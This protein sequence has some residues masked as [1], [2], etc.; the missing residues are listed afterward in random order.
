MTLVAGNGWVAS[1]SNAIRTFAGPVPVGGG[2]NALMVLKINDNFTG[3]R[4][5]NSAEITKAD[6]DTNPNNTPPTDRDST[7]GNDVAS[8]DDQ[9]KDIIEITPKPAPSTFDLAIV[10]KHIGA[11]PYTV[12][13]TV[14]FSLTVMNQGTEPAYS[15]EITDY[16]PAGL[17]LIDASWTSGFGTSTKTIAGPIASGASVSTTIKLRISPNFTGKTLTN[18][19]EISKADDDTNPTNTPPVDV[20]GILDNIQTNNGTAKD[21]VTNESNTTNA[22]ND[23]DNADIDR[24]DVLQNP[25]RGSIGNY[26]FLDNDGSNTQTS[27][28]TPVVGVKVYL[29]NSSGIKMDSTNT[30]N[31]GQYLFSNL[32]LDTYSVQFVAPVGNLFVVPNQ[33]G[34]TTKDSDA[35]S[36]GQTKQVTLTAAIPNLAV[37]DAGIKANPGCISDLIIT[38]GALVESCKGK[39]YP[40]LTGIVVVGSGDAGTIDWYKKA[41]GGVAVATGT[42]SYTPAGNVMVND[43]FYLEGRNTIQN[44][45][46]QFLPRKR[47]VIVAK[48]CIDTVDLALKKTVDTKIAKLG[49]VI[50]Y[51]IKV[52]NNSKTNATGVGVTDQLPAGLQYVSA[53]ATRGTYT[54]TTGIWTIGSVAALSGNPVVGDTV[55]LSIKAKVLS[56]GVTFNTAEISSADQKDKNSTPG[57]GIDGENDLDRVCITVPIKLCLGQGVEVVVPTNY[58]G[59]IWKDATGIVIPSNGNTVTFIKAGT[60]NFTA[61]NGQCPAG[62]CCPVIVEEVN[63][64]PAELCIPFTIVKKKKS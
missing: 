30:G 43:T 52:W 7:P 41:Q 24:I 13:D 28:D 49:D 45:I 44:A 20:D 10:K 26:V 15:V 58:T 54:T 53:T 11:S 51:T 14:T 18:E 21:D 29:L 2:L 40:T 6:N 62:G 48:N 9:D 3:S 25:I 59:I 56:E 31:D 35:G 46:C 38:S 8:E 23:L 33:G 17:T 16:M 4:L 19:V 5:V 63:C 34:D 22:S 57:N 42:L 64:C 27:G 12:G 1:G 61:T 37:L 60:Y 39:P 47:V 36:N 55:T 50:T 32:P